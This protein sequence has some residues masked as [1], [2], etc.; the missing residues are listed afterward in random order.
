MAHVLDQHAQNYP[1]LDGKIHQLRLL[2]SSK[3]WHELS[4]RLLDYIEEPKLQQGDS[5]IRLYEGFVREFES[6]IDPLKLAQIVT[7]A[8]DFFI[9]SQKGIEFL[10]EVDKRV[11]EDQAK[12]LLTIKMGS[13]A[14]KSNNIEEGLQ[15]IRTM[16][17][18]VEKS[19]DL[20]PLVHSAFHLLQAEYCAIKKNYEEFYQNALQY[21]AYTPEEKI[22]NQRKIQISVEMAVAV[23]V[24]KKIYNFS[25]LLDQPVF[26]AL[27]G[28]NDDWLYQMIKTFNTGNIKAY[29][30]TIEKYGNNVKSN[31]TLNQNI[32]TLN[33]KIKI[34]ALLELIFSLPKND[35]NVPFTSIG[36][37][38]GL[39]DDEIEPLIMRAMSLGLIKGTIDEIDRVVRVSWVVPRVLDLGR[40]GIMREKIE[41]WN[42]SLEGL[43]K[44]IEAENQS[45]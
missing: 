5:L 1:E 4:E 13:L 2:Y 45:A 44:T 25:E 27:E 40:I 34:M 29:D 22:S 19:G 11:K 23:L 16:A 33:E 9:S 18:R 14:L 30:Q 7:T 17:K 31:A 20:H 24:S 41:N 35:R 15:T 39:K 26:K 32:K 28:T 43:I 37:V 42:N 3:L 6:K 36:K 12:M 38:S 8:S 21:L 10:T